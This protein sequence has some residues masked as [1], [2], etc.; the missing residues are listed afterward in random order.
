M[1]ALIKKILSIFGAIFLI[2]IALA[3]VIPDPKQDSPS[4]APKPAAESSRQP[5]YRS[6]IKKYDEYKDKKVGDIR[7]ISK[8]LA[9]QIATGFAAQNEVP[10]EFFHT[11]YRCMGD[12]ARTKS[13]DLAVSTIMGWCLDN[14]KQDPA[15]FKEEQSAY[16]FY[17]FLEQFSRW[18]GSHP[19]SVEAIKQRMHDP[20]S[21]KHLD[22][23]FH[24][25][26]GQDNK[27]QVWITTKFTGT[28]AYGGRVQGVVQTRIDPDTGRVLE[29]KG[30]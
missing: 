20:E 8:D 11:F 18:D 26:R 28:N 27:V 16:S 24:F 19:P 4:G 13:A 14:Y 10:E 12:F 25:I 22:T 5:S 7:E 21:F 6:E 2:L 17:D 9:L 29:V 1:W 23:R 15:K 3:V 30:L